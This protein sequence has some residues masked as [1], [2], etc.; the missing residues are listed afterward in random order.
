MQHFPHITEEEFV[1]GC[2]AFYDKAVTA[3][4]SNALIE[5]ANT[6]GILSIKKE[7]KIRMPY[8]AAQ[9]VIE[10]AADQK[11]ELT[12]DEDHE[13]RSMMIT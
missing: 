10:T 9:E 8:G 13:V 5:V 2:K 12:N 1:K 6:D 7:Y 4:S 3:T 11:A